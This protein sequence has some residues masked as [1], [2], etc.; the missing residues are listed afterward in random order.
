MVQ[1]VAKQQ[2]IFVGHGHI[3]QSAFSTFYRKTGEFRPPKKGEHYLSGAIP[4]VYKAH[5]DHAEDNKFHI[6]TEV[7]AP[8]RY[9][10]HK[11]FRYKLDG[12]ANDRAWQ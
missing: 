7:E 6:M 5:A 2:R 3:G 8:P 10:E 12:P 11:G 4:E 1:S 9:I